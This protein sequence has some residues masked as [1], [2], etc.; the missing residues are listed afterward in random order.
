MALAP[1]QSAAQLVSLQYFE[2]KGK[3][4]S[5]SIGTHEFLLSSPA[6][7]FALALKLFPVV[8]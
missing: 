4:S 1:Y 5:N 7:Y 8:Y 2:F 6:S 3:C